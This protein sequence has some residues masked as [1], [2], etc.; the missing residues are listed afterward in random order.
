MLKKTSHTYLNLHPHHVP[1]LQK[2]CAMY[3]PFT[4]QVRKLV[5]CLR[6]R[7]PRLP[8]QCFWWS[9]MAFTQRSCI[10]LRKQHLQSYHWSVG[11]NP[12]YPKSPYVQHLKKHANSELQ[13]HVGRKTF[14]LV[15]RNINWYRS[16][17]SK[18]ES[19]VTTAFVFQLFLEFSYF[20]SYGPLKRQVFVC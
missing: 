12:V 17:F 7:V 20:I 1:Q 16:T 19:G 18:T 2:I 8:I 4:F 6:N 13:L 14:N 3:Q 9:V 10:R 15:F 5:H 11:E